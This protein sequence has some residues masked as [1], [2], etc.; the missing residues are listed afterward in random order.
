MPLLDHF[1]P[2]LRGPRRWEGFHHA[3]ATHIAEHLNRSALPADFFAEPEIGLGPAIQLSQL[4]NCMDVCEVR[5]YQD[6]EKPQL[7]T[8]IELVCPANKVRPGGSQTFTTK[9]ASYLKESVPVIVVDI[10]TERTAKLHSDLMIALFDSQTDGAS[11]NHLYSA[12]YRPVG[13]QNQGRI[14][15]W[16]EEFTLGDP[17]PV[18]PLWLKSDLCLPLQLEETYNTTCAGLRIPS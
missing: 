10:V 11:P 5:V 2:P 7:C 1:H 13:L 6:M 12:T 3:W 17:L 15:I 9:C 18:M 8:V 4:N 16:L 14:E